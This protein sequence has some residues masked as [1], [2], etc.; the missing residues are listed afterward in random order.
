MQ[1]KGV[2]SALR[3]EPHP[4]RKQPLTL[5]TLPNRSHSPLAA[6]G[7]LD[8]GSGLDAGLRASGGLTGILRAQ[9]LSLRRFCLTELKS[10]RDK[11]DP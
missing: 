4:L 10:S 9:V 7:V 3:K 8:S 2:D 1:E 6:A 5:H 11:L